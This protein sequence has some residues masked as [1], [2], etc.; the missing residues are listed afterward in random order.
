MPALK[1]YTLLMVA[2]PIVLVAGLVWVNTV[3][4]TLL[5]E[6]HA[7]LPPFTLAMQ[8]APS[9]PA[10]PPPDNSAL[11]LSQMSNVVLAFFTFVSGMFNAWLSYKLKIA[12]KDMQASINDNTA[13]TKQTNIVARAT[14]TT[15]NESVVKMAEEVLADKTNHK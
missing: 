2:I 10:A 5:K 1:T 13:I 15:V 9:S 14:N 7:E 11:W 8:A 6:S 12:T 3:G 4:V